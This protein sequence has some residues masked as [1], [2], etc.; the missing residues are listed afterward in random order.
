MS[1]GAFIF[2]LLNLTNIFFLSLTNLLQI[3]RI[4]PDFDETTRTFIAIGYFK[5]K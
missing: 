3:H 4:V 2:N 1:I 5:S